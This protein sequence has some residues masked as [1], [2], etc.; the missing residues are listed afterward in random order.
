MELRR[1]VA[2]FGGVPP[3]SASGARIT[4]ECPE[5]PRRDEA[6][7]ALGAL[8]CW[9]QPVDRVAAPCALT[10]LIPTGRDEQPAQLDT[11]E[12]VQPEH[13]ERSP[14]CER[15]IHRGDKA[16]VGAGAWFCHSVPDAG[17]PAL[18][19]DAWLPCI[20]GEVPRRPHAPPRPARS[21]ALPVGAAVGCLLSRMVVDRE[22]LRQWLGQKWP[23]RC[24]PRQYLI[25]IR[26]TEVI[27][28]IRTSKIATIGQVD[29][30][31]AE[32]PTLANAVLVLELCVVATRKLVFDRRPERV[33]HSKS[34]E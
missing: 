7:T 1:V 5:Q 16:P 23:L 17:C 34:D 8:P 9:R 19:H 3:A 4:P 18:L 21:D 15:C 20:L 33:P 25:G 14:E 2:T 24:I 26:V 28:K 11:N 10:I 13:A 30:V 29:I 27:R 31:M 22:P 32:Q 6:A 12:H